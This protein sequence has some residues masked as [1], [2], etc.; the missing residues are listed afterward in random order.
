MLAAR[1]GPDIAEEMDV[2][3][4]A[5]RYRLL[6]G[7]N[8]NALVRFLFNDPECLTPVSVV[9]NHNGT[10]SV[11]FQ[12]VSDQVNDRIHVR[13]LLFRFQDFC[14]SSSGGQVSVSH[15][16]S[17]FLESSLQDDDFHHTGFWGIN[18]SCLPVL[19]CPYLRLPPRQPL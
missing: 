14:K 11:G 17:R 2:S 19:D 16:R 3:L 9:R 18:L 7:N 15:E 5:L 1:P 6:Q 4:H 10:L 12:A 13:G 8:S